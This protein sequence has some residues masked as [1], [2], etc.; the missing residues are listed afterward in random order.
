MASSYT[1]NLGIE[2]PGSGEQAGT[3]GSTDNTNY[4]LLDE[5]INGIISITLG[6][7]GSSGSPNDLPI[8][9][10]A[11]STGRNF[12]ITITDAGDLGADVFVQLTPNNAEKVA[13]F[14]NS[15]SGSQDLYLFQGTYNASRDYVVSA[16]DTVRVAFSGGGASASTVTAITTTTG[17][18]DMS[19]ASAETA[20]DKVFMQSH[21]ELGTRSSGIEDIEVGEF[22]SYY[23]AIGGNDVTI[24]LNTSASV[25]TG[26]KL[27]TGRIWV[28]LNAAYSGLAV[29]TDVGSAVAVG[30]APTTSGEDALLVWEY[31]RTAGGTER[32]WSQW[33]NDS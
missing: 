8:T 1:D 11:S 19:Y 16:G 13:Y 29:T 21:S 30:T 18:G 10:G 27:I 22:A 6:S 23:L 12:F 20:S 24:D 32:L 4:D 3:W 25:G 26:A 9:D 15:L 17:S 14:K 5:A 31:Q 28:H 2:K 7:A 33:V